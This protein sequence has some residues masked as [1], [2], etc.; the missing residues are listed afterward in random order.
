MQNNRAVALVKH[1]IRLV[2]TVKRQAFAKIRKRV[3][4]L[5]RQ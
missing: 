2:N 3:A 4:C 5:A 1:V